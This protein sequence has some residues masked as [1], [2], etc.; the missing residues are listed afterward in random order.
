MCEW[1]G[2]HPLAPLEAETSL[3]R[4]NGTGEWLKMALATRHGICAATP[5]VQPILPAIDPIA[6]ASVRN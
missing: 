6:A 2:R 1:L 4:R 3:V 5:A